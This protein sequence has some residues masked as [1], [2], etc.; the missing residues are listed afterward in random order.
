M[1]FLV[2]AAFLLLN[3]VWS[4]Q[5]SLWLVPLAVLA[6]P[7]WRLLLAWMT[8]DALVWVPRM[9]YYVGP[10][11]R[12]LPPDWFLGAVVA[13][14]LIVVA[15]MVLVVRSVLRPATDPVRTAG[16]AT[17]TRTGRLR[18]PRPSRAPTRRPVLS[19]SAPA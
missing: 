13:R 14:D 4:P 15:L 7:R 18:R 10:S 3:K 9:F 8:L 11:A 16:R 19:S 6:L 2:V 12:G 1:G 5:Y 17:T